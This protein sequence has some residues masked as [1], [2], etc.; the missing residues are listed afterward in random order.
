MVRRGEVSGVGAREKR[1]RRRRSV[2][3]GC[4]RHVPNDGDHGADPDVARWAGEPILTLQPGCSFLPVIVGP[5]T[6]PRITDAATAARSP[7]LAVLSALVHGRE[8]VAAAIGSAA[9]VGLRALAADRRKL[10][11]DLVLSTVNEAARVIL[12]AILEKRYEYRSGGAGRPG[13]VSRPRQKRGAAGRGA[14]G[15]QPGERRGGGAG[16]APP[17]RSGAFEALT[18]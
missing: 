8:E 12:E 15:P 7:E 5:E 14:R 17:P 18:P 13:V 11:V 4:C 6:V 2:V 10:Y 9:L 3:G 1:R 16:G